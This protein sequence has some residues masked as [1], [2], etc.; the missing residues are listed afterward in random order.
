MLLQNFLLRH[1]KL[2]RQAS[3]SRFCAKCM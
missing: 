1:S 2:S 3:P